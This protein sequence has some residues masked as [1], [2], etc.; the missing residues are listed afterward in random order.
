MLPSDMVPLAALSGIKAA[1]DMLVAAS[2][3]YPKLPKDDQ[4]AWLHSQIECS[5]STSLAC[6][7]ALQNLYKKLLPRALLPPPSRPEAPYR[8]CAMLEHAQC[9]SHALGD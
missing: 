8:P 6:K 9:Q 2:I 7:Q 4:A 3:N 1:K 5:G